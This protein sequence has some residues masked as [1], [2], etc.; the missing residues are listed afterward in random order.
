MKSHS[1][2]KDLCY[3]LK[4]ALIEVK[5]ILSSN[6]N[7][8]FVLKSCPFLFRIFVSLFFQLN[9]VLQFGIN[10]LNQSFVGLKHLFVVFLH[11]FGQ[12]F[13]KFVQRP[14]HQL[15][16]LNDYHQLFNDIFQPSYFLHQFL[17]SIIH[18]VR[19]WSDWVWNNV[20]LVI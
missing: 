14:L 13:H 20:W 10:I 5:E 6:I 16:K 4:L 11:I 2:Q 7:S 17:D 3:F 12:A 15:E 8:N 9:C 1:S 19:V 18:R